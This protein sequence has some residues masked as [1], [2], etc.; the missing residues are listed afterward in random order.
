MRFADNAEQAE[1]R[2][3]TRRFLQARSGIEEVRRVIDTP[4]G[5]DPA[6]WAELAHLGLLGLAAPEEYGG[7]GATLVEVA[8]VLREAGRALLPAP[9]LAT[10]IASGA[11]LVAE[12]DE[13]A[14]AGCPASPRARSSRRSRP[15]RDS[16]VPPATRRRPRCAARPPSGC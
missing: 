6:V 2:A 16:T 7:S 5:Y 8:V 3:V 9:L 14:A 15:T 10:S 12:D 11:L 1:L 4:A 13:P